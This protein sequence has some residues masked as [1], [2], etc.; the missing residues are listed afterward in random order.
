MSEPGAILAKPSGTYFA[1]HWRGEISLPQS[2][3]VNG[4]VIGFAWMVAFQPLA[5]LFV[6][7]VWWYVIA[8]I[9]D[10]AT[11]VWQLVGIWRSAGNYRGR[12]VW[13]I[14]ARVF[15][16]IAVFYGLLFPVFLLVQRHLI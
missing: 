4:V 14:L 15:S 13:P 9:A 5:D 11:I 6:I 8:C 3:W 1:R 10:Y 16:I 12:R 2:F 7:A